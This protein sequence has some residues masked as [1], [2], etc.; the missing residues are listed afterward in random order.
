MANHKSAKK[1]IRQNDKRRINNK[2][3]TSRL[4]T[5]IKKLRTFIEESN[6]EEALK[7]YPIVQA[8]MAKLAK[9][10]AIRKDTAGRRTGRLATQVA[11]L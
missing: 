7:Q 8:L 6:K 1:R 11:K 4:R 9:S 10:P 3:K 5:E 2:W